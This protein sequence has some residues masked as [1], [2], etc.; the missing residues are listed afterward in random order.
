VDPKLL[1]EKISETCEWVYPHVSSNG[2]GVE[3]TVSFSGKP[4]KME[5]EL[6][7]QIGPRIIAI[8]EEKCI[9]VCDW[10]GRIARQETLHKKIFRGNQVVGW[11]HEC[12]TC[13]KIYDPETKRLRDTRGKKT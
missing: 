1:I 7:D 2:T 3:K 11:Q 8:K 13:N 5:Y 10:C 6:N 12:R 9:H 4:Y